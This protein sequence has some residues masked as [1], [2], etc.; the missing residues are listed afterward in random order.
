VSSPAVDSS[1]GVNELRTVWGNSVS[2]TK[3]EP[4][5][6]LQTPSLPQR[7]WKFLQLGNNFDGSYQSKDTRVIWT[8]GPFPRHGYLGRQNASHGER[9]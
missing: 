7:L 2:L 8:D 4:H 9:N 6:L 3:F 5:Q 1:T